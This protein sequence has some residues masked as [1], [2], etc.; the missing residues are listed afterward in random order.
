METTAGVLDTGFEMPVELLSGSSAWNVATE[1]GHP[2]ES[3][4]RQSS[5]E[6]G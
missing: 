6:W 5:V 2:A 3:S 4:G 1:A